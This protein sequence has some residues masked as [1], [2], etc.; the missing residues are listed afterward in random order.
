VT[1]DAE[2]PLLSAAVVR[3]F[4]E[5]A[6]VVTPET[7][8]YLTGAV[9]VCTL[10]P[11]RTIPF[12]HVHLL[13]MNERDFPRQATPPTFDLMAH[14]GRRKGDRVRRDEDRQLFLDAVLSARARLH[15]S[16][17]GESD[18]SG[19]PRNPSVL[20]TELLEVLQQRFELEDGSP[21]LD[22]LVRRHPL[23][24]FSAAYD[25]VTRITYEDLWTHAA[26]GPD[27]ARAADHSPPD[28][29]PD[30]VV[31]DLLVVS[32]SALRQF[33]RRPA[34]WYLR[35][36]LDVRVPEDIDTVDDDE[37]MAL[38]AL[39]RHGLATAALGAMRE[40]RFDAWAARARASGALPHGLA[41][42]RALEGWR[43]E[44]GALLAND[45]ARAPVSARRIDLALPGVRI[46]GE[47]ERCGPAGYLH[48]R[49]GKASPRDL[50]DA[51]VAQLLL[52]ASG[53]PASSVVFDVEKAHRFA[54]VEQDVACDALAELVALYRLAATQ[55]VPLFVRTSQ[56]RALADDDVKALNAWGTDAERRKPGERGAPA[57]R[58]DDDV[59]LLWGDRA[60]PPDG[61]QDCALQA[62]RLFAQV[63][64]SGKAKKKGGAQAA[65]AGDEATS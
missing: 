43:N 12:A 49:V 40:D 25:G 21:L 28:A 22:R 64:A 24:P 39:E 29:P 17:V 42:E 31:D 13:G 26:T 4:L 61:W 57:E 59:F 7:P 38:D 44:L 58:H 5:D 36:V 2:A 47:L 19:Q 46:V 63:Q 41:G 16:Y 56:A 35:N 37:P 1:G 15:L 23:Q 10:L 60:E 27:A 20:V 8:R 30:V 14:G 34:A 51:Y 3:E 11:M 6:W 9:T 62:Y 45:G 33:L 50:A 32:P 54:A 18:R 53:L 65:D 55:P 52:C 48:L